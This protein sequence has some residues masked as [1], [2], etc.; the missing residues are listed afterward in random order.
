MKKLLLKI[1]YLFIILVGVV[2]AAPKDA[3]TNDTADLKHLQMKQ[4][5][6][7][8]NKG[9][10][11]SLVIFVR[12]ADQDE[13]TT[14]KSFFDS[15]FKGITYPSVYSYF[16]E[17]S[18]GALDVN[19]HF[20]PSSDSS[21]LS[22]QDIYPIQYYKYYDSK[23]A[24][25]GFKT[26]A[27]LALRKD[28]L[29]MRIAN[30]LNN[31]IVNVSIF[32]SDSDKVIDALN[33][34]IKDNTLYPLFYANHIQ[35][36]NYLEIQGLA[37]KSY[38]L[39]SE[40]DLDY[41]GFTHILHNIFHSFGAPDFIPNKSS[42]SSSKWDL[43]FTYRDLPPHMCAYSKYTYGKWIDTIPE[44][45]SSG[46]YSLKPITSKTNNCFMIR[47]PHSSNEY[48]ILEYRKKEGRFESSLPGSGLVIYK[49]NASLLGKGNLENQPEE[50]YIYTNFCNENTRTYFNNFSNPKAVLSDGSYS[51]IDIYEISNCGDTI[52][53]KVNFEPRPFIL[54]PADRKWNISPLPQISWSSVNNAKYYNLEISRDSLFSQIDFI[55]NNIKDTYFQIE[56][57]LIGDTTYYLRVNCLDSLSN[58]LSKWSVT[59]QFDVIN[60]KA[61][62]IYPGNS[63]LIKDRLPTLNWSSNYNNEVNIFLS[64]DS[65]FKSICFYKNNLNTKSVKIDSLLKLD[66]KYY[67]KV[68]TIYSKSFSVESEVFSFTIQKGGFGLIKQ[69]QPQSFCK[70]S[71]AELMIDAYGDNNLYAWSKDGFPLTSTNSSKL[72]INNFNENDI[73]VYDCK[74][75]NTESPDY[76]QTNKFSVGLIKTIEIQPYSNIYSYQENAQIS[77]YVYTLNALY[78]SYQWFK[79]NSELIDNENM[80]GTKTNV[81]KIFHARASD[82]DSNYKLRVINNL[83]NDTAYAY[84]SLLDIKN[85]VPA[86][87]DKGISI[88]I[89]PNPCDEN[90]KIID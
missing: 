2:H 30:Y 80:S 79:N 83:C 71:I 43:M 78:N 26:T 32:D 63:E 27:E 59:T 64:E 70:N 77:F 25:L 40:S 15:V 39:T 42:P 20:F 81:L 11:N 62:L 82:I 50:L 54:S 76:I 3:V 5:K 10:L 1:L 8:P 47:S 28:S 41:D 68:V 60:T 16:K 90:A 56:N 66:T 65:T 52:S 12:F 18:Y 87:E 4:L 58:T 48:F 9:V 73:G 57:G 24:P 75:L 61:N 89:A 14:P 37:V 23:S 67:W 84:F 21:I 86:S 29:I 19:S 17:V 45:T 44:I 88:E 46:E 34:I 36:S 35:V 13:F 74:I 38:A 49:I 22:F 7:A 6:T 53:F 69:P 85:S 55:Y 31:H 33:I 51:D 72:I